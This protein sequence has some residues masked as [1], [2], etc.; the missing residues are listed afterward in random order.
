MHEK[1]LTKLR[2]NCAKHLPASP[3]AWREHIIG[4][5]LKQYIL[6]V[7]CFLF[8]FAA[9]SWLKLD[10]QSVAVV[11]RDIEPGTV[12]QNADIQTLVYSGRYRM[13]NGTIRCWFT[14]NDRALGHTAIRHISKY[15]PI[16]IRDLTERIAL[17]TLVPTQ[18]RVYSH[19]RAA[20]IKWRLLLERAYGC[21]G[22]SCEVAVDNDLNLCLQLLH[23]P[24]VNGRP[25]VSSG[26]R[27]RSIAGS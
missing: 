3:S 12:L 1:I 11:T 24:R 18:L 17:P 15:E 2:P 16:T 10:S 23:Q 26:C 13:P 6:A 19:R 9:L 22:F 14:C 8:T 21:F 4:P 5:A 27:A 20:R 25:S 7:A